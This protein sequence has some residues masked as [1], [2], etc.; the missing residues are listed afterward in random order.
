DDGGLRPV[1]WTGF[2]PKL[3]RYQGELV[4]K[5]EVLDRFRLKA[6]AA[7]EAGGPVSGQDWTSLDLVL[8]TIVAELESG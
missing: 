1:Q 6:E 2:N 4:G 7:L 8:D 3:G 5:G